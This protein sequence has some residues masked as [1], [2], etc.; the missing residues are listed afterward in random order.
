MNKATFSV[1]EVSNFLTRNNKPIAARC[2]LDFWGERI[3]NEDL[4]IVLFVLFGYEQAYK[5]FRAMECEVS[6]HLNICA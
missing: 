6:Q 5:L 4:Q 3:T 1:Y 2:L